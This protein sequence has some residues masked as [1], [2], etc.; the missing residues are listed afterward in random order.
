MKTLIAIPCMDQVPV[1][2]CQSLALLT[3]PENTQLAMNPGS[4]IYT[5]RDR[6]AQLAIEAEADYVLP[7]SAAIYTCFVRPP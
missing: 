4:L 6:L 1:P 7:K 3:K 5:S 2:F